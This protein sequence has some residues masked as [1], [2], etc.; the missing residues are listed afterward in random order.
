MT[1]KTATIRLS[2][3]VESIGESQ[4]LAMGRAAS[5]MRAQGIDV[6]DFGPGEPDFPTPDHIKRAAAQA[7]EDNFTKY[8]PSAGTPDLRA[9]ICEWH[10]REL[11][12]SYQ[13]SECIAAMGGKG[14]L[15]GIFN[16]LVNPGEAVLIPAP[17][18]VTFPEV[19]RYLGATPV[20]VPT[21]EEE[22]FRLTAA[23]LEQ[24][25]VDGTR[26]VIANSPSNPSGAVIAEDEFKRI[27][28]L[29]RERDAWLVADECYSHFVYEGTPFSIASVA[30]SKAHVIV[31]GSLSKTFAMTG[32]RIGYALA[33]APVINAMNRLQSHAL[34]NP[35][36]ITQRA[37]IEALRGPME[38]VA[39]MLAEYALRRKRIVAGLNDIPKVTCTDPKGAFYA[40]PNFREWMDANGVAT[41]TDLAKRLLDKAR[42]VTV[43]GEAFGTADHLRFSYA[44]SMERID[45]GLRRLRNFFSP[46]DTTS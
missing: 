40:Y 21:R 17:Y 45:E 44:I 27:L 46:I 23:D 5:E 38:P 39:A 29:C 9:A 6:V 4:T 15:F 43:P 34:S 19:I 30:D 18:W 22:G 25:W 42:V 28:D 37:A 32:W 8:T 26:A 35:N 7:L 2:D 11:G 10:A 14:A 31:A 1:R 41:T 13:P 12:S 20:F 36:S 16:A 24:H 33:P 3:R